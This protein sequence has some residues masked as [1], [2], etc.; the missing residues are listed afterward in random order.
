MELLDCLFVCMFG[1]L[2]GWLDF[3]AYI[4][5]VGYLM[6]NPVFTNILNIICKLIL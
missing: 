5:I 6:P 3:M 2:V 1:W 4:T